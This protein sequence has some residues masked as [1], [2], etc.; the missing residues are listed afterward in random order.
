MYKVEARKRLLS[1]LPIE[2]SFAFV[3]TCAERALVES[4]KVA[5]WKEKLKDYPLKE[6]VE[7]L[8][9]S[10]MGNHIQYEGQVKS[11]HYRCM[12]LIPETEDDP[13]PDPSLMFT[14][15][16]V[17]LG[18][19][20]IMVPDKAAELSA[21]GASLMINLVGTVYEDSDLMSE[22]EEDWQTRAVDLLASR[23]ERAVTR[24]TL[25]IP[26]YPRGD[27]SEEYLSGENW[28]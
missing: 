24:D 8:W 17:C 19:R 16:I 25:R 7:L 23:G 21:E 27:V 12:E 26:E 22:Q 4:E 6:G 14:A 20:I 28:D 9:S 15:Q 13:R 2:S 3:A 1:K 18:L 10:A 5:V 11:V